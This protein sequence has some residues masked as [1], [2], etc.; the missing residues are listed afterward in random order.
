MPCGAG[1]KMSIRK[2]KEAREQ[3][4]STQG[5]IVFR[6]LTRKYLYI[7]SVEN[8][9]F[10]WSIDAQNYKYITKMFAQDNLRILGNNESS[11]SAPDFAFFIIVNDDNN[12]LAVLQAQYRVKETTEVEVD[13]AGKSL[14]EKIKFNKSYETISAQE[15]PLPVWDVNSIMNK[16]E[17]KYPKFVE[18]GKMLDGT[19]DVVV[20]DEKEVVENKKKNDVI[21]DFDNPQEPL[22]EVEDEKT[23]LLKEL[24]EEL[25]FLQEL[26]QDDIIEQEIKELKEKIEALK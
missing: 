7:A 20:E 19:E 9:D 25:L 1:G 12:I 13:N 10:V 8:N 17:E 11:Y 18:E 21:I 23:I 3:R 5:K 6:D 4:K 2:M 26:E 14:Q 15:Q 16:L 22:V 24:N